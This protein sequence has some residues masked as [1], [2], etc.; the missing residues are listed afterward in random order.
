MFSL[1]GWWK[2]R[3]TRVITCPE[4]SQP[5]AVKL[6]DHIDIRACSRW[7]EKQGCGQECLRQIEAAPADCLIGNVFTRWYSGSKCPYCSKILTPA[8]WTEHKPAL[9]GPDGKSLEWDEVRPEE[10]VKLMATHRPICWNCHIAIGF[11]RDHS[12]MVVDRD[13]RR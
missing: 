11:R 1:L 12:D 10:L 9:M 4:N 5:A 13:F 7:P 3:G 2:Y 8:D 6:R